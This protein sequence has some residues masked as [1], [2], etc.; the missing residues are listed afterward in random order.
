MSHHVRRPPMCVCASRA[1]SGLNGPHRASSRD[2]CVCLPSL[3]PALETHANERPSATRDANWSPS[4]NR[5]TE[6]N[7]SSLLTAATPGPTFRGPGLDHIHLFCLCYQVVVPRV[8]HQLL[9][10]PPP[11]LFAHFQLMFNNAFCCCFVVVK[12]S[13]VTFPRAVFADQVH[14]LID[15]PGS[16]VRPGR[17]YWHLGEPLGELAAS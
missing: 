16:H 14:G 5:T 7:C 1:G 13:R 8:K 17:R 9:Y 2:E 11:G 6:G 3:R 10:L 15:E 12:A 4:L